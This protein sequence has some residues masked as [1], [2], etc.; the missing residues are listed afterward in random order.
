MNLGIGGRGVHPAFGQFEGLLD[1]AGDA[2]AHFKEL[3]FAVA[4]AHAAFDAVEPGIGPGPAYGFVQ[5]RHAFFVALPQQ[6]EARSSGF[7]DGLHIF[8][9]GQLRCKNKLPGGTCI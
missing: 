7:G 1:F 8:D 2:V 3:A 6:Y 5:I 9:C 4:S